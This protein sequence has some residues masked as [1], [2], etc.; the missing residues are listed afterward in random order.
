MNLL[1]IFANLALDSAEYV[2]SFFSEGDADF[3]LLSMGHDATV[4]DVSIKAQEL[5][6][7]INKAYQDGISFSSLEDAYKTIEN[8]SDVYAAI[9]GFAT[10]ID[11][12][13]VALSLI[14]I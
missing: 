10:E 2:S 3:L 13:H 12:T 14:H 9:N 8:L 6:G 1:S 7:T 11:D 4:G 5:Q